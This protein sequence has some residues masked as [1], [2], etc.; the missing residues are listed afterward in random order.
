MP[1]LIPTI[2]PPEKTQAQRVAEAIIAESN[3]HFLKRLET[4]K[5]LWEQLWEN[6]TATPT[7]IL[8]ELGPKAVTLFQAAGAGVADLEVLA[9]LMGSNA[10]ELLG[11]AKYLSVA[12]PVNFNAD[13]TVTL[14]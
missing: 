5:S 7:E 9:K 14:K 4:F 8:A 1:E 3:Q 13:G 2:P 11:N 10:E 12:A 6:P